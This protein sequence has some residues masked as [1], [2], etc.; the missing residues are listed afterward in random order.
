MVT[1]VLDLAPFLALT[2]EQFLEFCRRHS[3]LR[4][5]RTARGEIVVMPPTGG[6]TGNRNTILLSRLQ[7]WTESNQ[8]KVF[9]SSTGFLLPNGA[10]RSPDA[11]WIPEARWQ[12]LSREERESFPPLC[13]DLVVELLSPTDSRPATREKMA[14]Y[15]AN[16]A[17]LGWLID[18]RTREVEIW[19]A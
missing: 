10:Q 14:E 11:S 15:A 18:P 9:D 5:E 6:E 4:I 16:G 17:R 7:T 19:R 12:T 13:P 3:D 2:R 8:G 1:I